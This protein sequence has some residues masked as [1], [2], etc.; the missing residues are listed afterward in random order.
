V[1][2]QIST[3]DPYEYSSNMTMLCIWTWE[4]F[5]PS[6][7]KWLQRQNEKEKRHLIDVQF[8]TDKKLTTGQDRQ[9]KAIFSV[10][11]PT[12]FRANKDCLLKLYDN[13][14][15]K[16]SFLWAFLGNTCLHW[17]YFIWLAEG[18]ATILLCKTC[19]HAVNH[20][21]IA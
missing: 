21:L 16:N 1:E 9:K 14:I 19:L 20:R 12:R 13:Q 15:I 8:S 4:R 11:D 7:W 10:L 5:R 17:D 18:V 2:I 3:L 6:V